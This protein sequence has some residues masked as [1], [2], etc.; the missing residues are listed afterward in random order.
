MASLRPKTDPVALA[1][2]KTVITNLEI[3]T[4][5]AVTGIT[6]DSTDVH[7]GDLFVALPG[8]KTHGATFAAQVVNKGAS[9]VL[10]DQ[11]GSQIIADSTDVPVIIME[12]LRENLGLISSLIYQNPSKKLKVFGITG[13]NG[14]TTTSWLLHQGLEAAGIKTGLLGT[15]GIKIGNI[16][17]SSE[18]TTP[19][20]PQLQALLALAVEQD[21]SA[22]VMEIS[23]HALAMHRADG[24]WFEAV[25]FTNLSHDHLDFHGDM[26]TY[27]QV[28]KRLFTKEFSKFAAISLADAWGQRLASECEIDKTTVGTKEYANWILHD[29]SPALGHVDF[30]VFTPL[31]NDLE[32]K[33]E[34][35]GAFNAFNA[36]LSLAMTSQLNL[37]RE[38]FIEGIRKAHIPGRME[39]IL[40]PG[41]ALAVVDY[42]HTPD[43][44]SAVIETLRSQ[45]HGRVIAVLGAGGNRDSQKRKMMGTAVSSADLIVV[46]DDNPRDEDP[47]NI[48]STLISGIADKSKV[49]EIAD[50]KEAIFYAAANSNESDTIVVLGKGHEDYQETKGTRTRFLDSEVTL[51]ALSEVS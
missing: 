15:A 38:A 28:K 40:V 32:I 9:A 30:N 26:E 48:R 20:A 10:T 2:L 17:I 42:A 21:L 34:F 25:G 6:A 36:T 39:P 18:R 41:R 47:A 49:I 5:V 45:T 31:K 7:A 51:Q 4:D 8:E 43:A 1:A 27:F 16:E 12:S 33:L 23:S 50:R 24:I 19:E 37:N 11:Q 44:I 35:A 22:V 29:V 14:K 46:T 13:T 3:N